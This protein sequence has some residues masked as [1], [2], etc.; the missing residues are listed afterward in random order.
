M[1]LVFYTIGI[2]LMGALIRIAALWNK[3]AR[4]WVTGRKDIFSSLHASFDENIYPIA[5]F[6]CASLGEFEQARPV[7]E[8]FRTKHPHYRILLTFYSPSGYEIRKNYE[9]ADWVFYLPLDTGSN[10]KR[11]IETVRPA[12]VFFA[13]YEFWHYYLAELRNQAIPTILFSAIFRQDQAFFKFYG[14]FFRNML[15]CFTHIFV[16]NTSSLALLKDIDLE[17]VSVAGDT[18][19]DRV[20]KIAETKK[21]IPLA[22]TFKAD[23][24]LLI[25]GSAWQG[26]LDLLT[27]YLNQYTKPL[28]ILIAPHEIKEETLQ[29]IESAFTKKTIRLSKAV[30]NSIATYDVLLID[31]IGLLSSLYQY[32][33]FAFIGGGFY[34]G[35]HSI[36]EPAVFG[37]P[38]FFGPNYKKFQEAF[39]LIEEGGAFSVKNTAEFIPIFEKLYS[40]ATLRKEVSDRVQMYIRKKL[41]ATEKILKEID[42][43]Y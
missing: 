5:W 20:S 40:D 12:I 43:L 7:I 31:S 9:Y 3:K 19:I 37:M 15:T 14:Q 8:G 6:H 22:A 33:D 21:D 38:I 13:K 16:Q 10:A 4:Q 42:L 18:R 1:M 23:Q 2:Y 35:I 17:N 26:D 11:F 24:P 30:D 27:G 32:G 36:L 29:S 39:D 41:G 34:D 25:V 28:K